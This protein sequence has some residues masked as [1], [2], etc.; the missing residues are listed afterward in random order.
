MVNISR[1]LIKL[2]KIKYTHMVIFKTIVPSKDIANFVWSAIFDRIE[3]LSSLEYSM[4]LCFVGAEHVKRY[5]F[6]KKVTAIIS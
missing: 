2:C 4:P 5:L 6:Y 3:H 1:Q